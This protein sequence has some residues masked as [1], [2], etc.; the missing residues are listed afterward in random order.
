MGVFNH[1][2][3]VDAVL[4][5][6]LFAPSGVS[7][8]DNADIPIVGTCIKAFQNIYVSRS[9]HGSAEQ[10]AANRTPNGAKAPS[11]SDMIAER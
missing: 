3:W 1:S 7:L 11:V 6:W 2:A 9:A 10:E 5:M 8:S 4:L